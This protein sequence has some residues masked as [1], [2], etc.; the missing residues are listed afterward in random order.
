[1]IY[2][3]VTF[4]T[5]SSSLISLAIAALLAFPLMIVSVD[6][7]VSF[8][9]G[10]LLSTALLHVL[11][12]AFETIGDPH[13][14]FAVLLGGLFTFFL[15]E[16]AA[17]MRHSHHHE[18]DGHGHQH[19]F[20]QKEAGRGGYVILLGDTLHNFCDGIVISAAFLADIKLG[21]LTTLSIVAHEIPQE[22]GDFIVLINAGFTKKRA[23]LYNA[24]SGAVALLG[25]L[26]G[27][28]FLSHLE[29]WIPYVL[30]ISASS[31]IYIALA[32]LMP[33]IQKQN[34]LRQNLP[35]VGLIALGVGLIVVLNRWVH[36]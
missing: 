4:A 15:L 13:R 20:D 31:F 2:L 22:V 33:Q 29:Q 26:V 7:M 11:P 9:I 21:V 8:S 36:V 14:L 12:E 24:I 10:M 34:Q 1:M 35:Q 28:T 27:L 18:N 16:K 23:F 6:R 19:G 30:V 17:L 5:L 25:G 32:D 3:Y